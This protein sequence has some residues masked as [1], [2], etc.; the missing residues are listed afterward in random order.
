MGRKSNKRAK[1]E[2][3][4]V[5]QARQQKISIRYLFM[6]STCVLLFF[7][8]FFRGLFFERELRVVHIATFILI[9]IWALTNYQD[10]N[11]PV[12]RYKYEYFLFAAVAM[13]IITVPFAASR[14]LALLEALKYVNYLA[15]YILVRD[16]VV[17]TR[18]P[19]RYL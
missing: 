15:V 16:L 6:I 12:V 1:L 11:L 5:A 19:T 10:K 3:I 13:Y 17:R 2:E 18:T 7:P 9:L 4:N 8:A 14:R